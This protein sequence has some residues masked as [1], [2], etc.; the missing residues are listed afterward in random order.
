MAFGYFDRGTDGDD[1]L[2]ASLTQ[3]S[4]LEGGAGD[5][6]YYVYHRDDKTVEFNGEGGGI[7]NVHSTV[8]WALGVNLENLYLEGSANIGGSGNDGDNIIVGNSGMNSLRGGAG[9]D[10]IDG[11]AGDDVISG[12]SGRDVL[13]GGAGADKFIFDA[14]LTSGNLDHIT[15]FQ[16]GLD[17]IVLDSSIFGVFNNSTPIYNG[18]AQLVDGTGVDNHLILR[19]GNEISQK[20]APT[21]IYDSTSGNVSF[22]A[23]GTA[24]AGKAV[25]FATLDTKP[26]ELHAD[27]FLVYTAPLYA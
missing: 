19:P 1:V 13:T 5:D 17:K 27:D 2:Y 15:D 25:V 12:G 10:T 20:G 26:V 8:T 23:D 7:D 4:R 16:V 21:I 22:D 14:S 6:T 18:Y 9:S 11:G 3:A 24:G